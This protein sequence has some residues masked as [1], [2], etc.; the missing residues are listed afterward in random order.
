MWHQLLSPSH[1]NWER[2]HQSMA[3][4]KHNL[5]SINLKH[6]ARCAYI[7]YM[8]IYVM[9]IL[10]TMVIKVLLI[11]T[12]FSIHFNRNL[13]SLAHCVVCNHFVCDHIFPLLCPIC[14]LPDARARC[15]PGQVVPLASA[16]AGS[17][18]APIFPNC[19]TISP[20][21][22]VQASRL[23]LVAGAQS[24]SPLGASSQQM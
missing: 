24:S 1:S 11:K 4:V 18:L 20:R 10:S 9:A 16:Q 5:E 17:L 23:Y 22:R 15:H 21:P 14:Q 12:P 6:C 3:P 7:Y 2:F 19:Y 13:S 8:Y